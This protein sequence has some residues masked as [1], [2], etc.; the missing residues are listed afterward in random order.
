MK[1]SIIIP[2]YNEDSTIVPL[3]ENVKKAPLPENVLKEII[4]V[5]DGSNDKTRAL[6]KQYANDP[7]YKV[8]R[9]SENQGKTAALKTGIEQA[10]GD[11]LIIQDADLEY[12]PRDFHK[13]IQPIMNGQT[14]IVYGSRFKGTI[15]DMKFI[16]RFANVFSNITFNIIYFPARLSDINTCYKAFKSDLIKSL[17][18]ESKNFTFETEMTAKLIRSNHKILE[19]P[20]DYIARPKTEGKKI[21]WGKAMEMYWGMFRFRFYKPKN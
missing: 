21:N 10:S 14:S 11:I 16:N 17:T 4:I 19:V 1:L 20:I 5:D 13:I 8:I 2:V 7:Q 6:L 3:L 18:I 9:H 12:D 15:K